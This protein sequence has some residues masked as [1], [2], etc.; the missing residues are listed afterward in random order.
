[1]PVPPRRVMNATVFLYRTE[2]E[3]RSGDAH[4]ASGFIVGVPAL[5]EEF[6][7]QAGPTGWH[8]YGVTAPHVIAKGVR[9]IRKT[10]RLGDRPPHLLFDHPPPI[11]TVDILTSPE[12]IQHSFADVAIAPL[13]MKVGPP[14]QH[15][16]MP[17]IDIGRFVT[18]VHRDIL[19]YLGGPTVGDEVFMVGRFS[20]IPDRSENNPVARFGYIAT[21]PFTMTHGDGVYKQSYLAEMR[22]NDMFS[23]SPVFSYVP[24]K[25]QLD[26]TDREEAGKGWERSPFN[27]LKGQVLVLGVD[28]GHLQEPVTVEADDTELGRNVKLSARINSAMAV[29]TPANYIGDMLHMPELKKQREK[30]ETDFAKSVAESNVEMDFDRGS[31]D[32]TPMTREAFFDAFAVLVGP[33]N[34]N[35]EGPHTEGKS[36]TS[37]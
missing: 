23:G 26:D 31:E 8:L 28:V 29:V 15:R 21:L 22:S 35:S 1:M 33:Q 20:G 4:G 6:I 32:A 3:A 37:E 36:E 18:D 30:E 11:T 34:E 13:G 12:W 2:A 17:W 19:T 14:I 24:K 10:T 27:L 25:D 7:T 5:R 9:V 16:L